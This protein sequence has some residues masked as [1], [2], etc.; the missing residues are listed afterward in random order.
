MKSSGEEI[1]V[2]CLIV[3]R[4]WLLIHLFVQHTDLV[5]IIIRAHVRQGILARFV[6]RHR[7]V[8]V[9][10]EQI[11]LCVQEMVHVREQII[12]CVMLVMVAPIVMF[13][14]VVE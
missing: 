14:H 10:L 2:V 12:A 9:W 1:I 5:S 3:I 8:M 6:A 7:H 11:L 13:S 4:C